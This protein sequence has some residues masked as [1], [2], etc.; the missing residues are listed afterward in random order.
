MSKEKNRDNKIKKG[1]KSVD[2]W[3]IVAIALPIILVVGL[4]AFIVLPNPII[5]WN[6]LN[7]ATDFLDSATNSTVI[8]TDPMK[9]DELFAD[10]EEILRGEDADRF[11]EKL[12]TVTKNVKYS[13][14]NTDSIGIWKLKIVVNSNSE[15]CKIYIDENAVYLADK[16]RVIEYSIKNSEKEAYKAFYESVEKLLE[17]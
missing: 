8:I 3:Y 7:K 9:S 1:K 6:E 4:I 17:S 12:K 10:A 5:A 16:N 2:K 13:E 14:I 15:E 11:V